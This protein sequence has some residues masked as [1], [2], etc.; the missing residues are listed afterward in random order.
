MT[1]TAQ[2]Y[3]DMQTNDSRIEGSTVTIERDGADWALR[4]ELWLPH[5]RKKVFPFFS[6]A[7]NLDA[8]TPPWLHF[9]ILTPRPI[10]MFAGARIDY[11]LRIHGLPIRWRTVITEWNPP[12]HFIDEQEH[13][14][15]QRWHHLHTFTSQNREGVQGTLCRDVVHH[16][17]LGGALVHRWF[18]RKDVTRIFE[19]RQ[20]RL[21]ELFVTASAN[22]R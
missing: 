17:A 4:C 6:D 1:M 3:P 22:N 21:R 8:I 18:V 10:P 15:Y 14:P 20:Q 9:Q 13:G 11:K 2:T 12:H 19:F 16:R 7:Y 5:A